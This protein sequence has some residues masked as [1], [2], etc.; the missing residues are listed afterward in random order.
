MHW[1]A[2]RSVALLFLLCI[3]AFALFD[4]IEASAAMLVGWGQNGY[5][6]LGTPLPNE[7]CTPFVC[8]KTPSP[9]SGLS[10]VTQ[11]APA[12]THTLALLANGTVVAWGYNGNGELGNSSTDESNTPVAVS[13]IANAVQVSADYSHSLAL[14]ADGRVMAW[15]ENGYGQLGTGSTEGP[16]ECPASCSIVP[17]PVP[18]LSDAVAISAG[19]GYSL[20]LLANGTVVAWGFDEDGTIGDGTGHQGSGCRCV[21]S[22][23]PVPGVSDAMAIS[24]GSYFGAALLADGRVMDWGADYEGQLGN[25]TSKTTEATCNCL[26]PV[27]VSGLS[28][29]TAIVAGGY[30]ALA[31]LPDGTLK[32]WGYNGDGELA[33]GSFTG[34]ESC[35]ADPC[36]KVPLTVAGVS[37]P[38][39]IAAGVFHTLALR[40]DGMVDAWGFNPWGQLGDGT[41]N[42][43]NHPL[44]VGG[45]AGASAVAAHDG[46]SFALLGPAQ[47]LSVGLAGAGAG[48]VGGPAG[49]LCPSGCSFRYPQGAVETLRAEP[50]AGS[51][52]A[53]FTGGCTGT[54]MC[55]VAMSQDQSVTAT[56]GP[57]RGTKITHAKVNNRRRSAT[58]RFTAPG[59]ITGY[60]CKLVGLGHHRRHRHKGA[61]RRRAALRRTHKPAFG[62]CGQARKT[63]KHLRRGRYIFRVRAVDILGVD[64]K[65]AVR[66]FAIKHPRSAKHRHRH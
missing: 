15:G 57:P 2:L 13:G 14:L 11:V 29:A 39:G 60:Q 49:I 21:T 41:T 50:A 25:G 6:A 27:V 9:V 28:G 53:G 62:G 59:A 5:G 40:S 34:P 45:L 43:A 33:T 17:R 19:N 31:L 10:D 7:S 55:R 23:T 3:A 1:K 30:H 37:G 16:E 47:T 44:L 66:R 58:F 46:E 22:P 63:Y 52:F 35:G 51:G 12:E 56:F 20:A 18:G 54:G 32:G 26:G 48:S 24:A 42:S 65:P 61:R 8:R 4:S 38:A 36:S 64:A